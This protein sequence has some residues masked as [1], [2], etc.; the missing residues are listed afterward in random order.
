MVL[1]SL[2]QEMLDLIKDLI[3]KSMAFGM[4]AKS[5]KDCHGG[6]EIKRGTGEKTK[7]CLELPSIRR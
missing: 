1:E 2:G 4:N 6:S 5:K 7:M 3:T